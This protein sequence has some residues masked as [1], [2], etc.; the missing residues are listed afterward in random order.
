[1]IA[2][3]DFQVRKNC[4]NLYDS[5]G[6]ICVHCGCCA[7]DK[8]A[9]YKARLRVLERWLEDQY[10][11]DMWDEDESLRKVQEQNVKANIR[12]FK[13]MIRYYRQRLGIGQKEV[14]HEQRSCG[15]LRTAKK[16]Q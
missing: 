11:F 6:E 16:G 10:A 15:I 14:Q 9:R 13:R 8:M 5:Y 2:F 4:W 12:S 1:M 3:I 7:K